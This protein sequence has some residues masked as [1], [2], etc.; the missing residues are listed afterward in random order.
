MHLPLNLLISNINNNNKNNILSR[1]FSMINL[2]QHRNIRTLV[3]K[4]PELALRRLC[5]AS[6][7]SQCCQCWQ[8]N[9][10]LQRQQWQQQQAM[11]LES[12]QDTW[13]GQVVC[14]WHWCPAARW[15]LGSLSSFNFQYNLK[16]DKWQKI[17]VVSAPSP[18]ICTEICKNIFPSSNSICSTLHSKVI[19]VRFFR[20]HLVNG[21]LVTWLLVTW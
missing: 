6:Q 18:T 16:W 1:F 21:H 7:C 13:I 9:V 19:F 15:N 10:L 8:A 17:N 11:L 14:A 3:D 4:R 20:C 2:Y 5:M 12:W